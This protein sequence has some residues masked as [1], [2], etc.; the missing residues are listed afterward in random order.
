MHTHTCATRV[1][2]AREADTTAPRIKQA[3]HLFISDM[4]T[5]V[6]VHIY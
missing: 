5:H 6:Y 4:Y 1:E 2:A 3:L